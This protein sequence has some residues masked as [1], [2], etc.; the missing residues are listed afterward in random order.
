M[1][2]IGFNGVPFALAIPNDLAFFGLTLHTQAIVFENV[3]ALGLAFSDAATMV[4]GG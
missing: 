3:N 1:F 2:N 4:I